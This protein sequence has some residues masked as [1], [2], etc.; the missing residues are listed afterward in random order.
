MRPLQWWAESAPTGRDRVKVSENLGAGRPCG[1][2]PET[3]SFFSTIISD[4][5]PN[6]KVFTGMGWL[7]D[8]GSISHLTTVSN[9]YSPEECMDE[10]ALNRKSNSQGC[11]AFT[12]VETIKRLACLQL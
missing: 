4:Q 2:I 10:C 1:Y 9:I 5:L 8:E 12:F 3:H 11:V 7:D 6:G